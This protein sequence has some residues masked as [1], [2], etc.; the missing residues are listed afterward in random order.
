[1]AR[2]GQPNIR[3]LSIETFS[4]DPV[5][6]AAL[7]DAF[8]AM[9][10][11]PKT[12]LVGSFNYSAIHG[13]PTADPDGRTASPAQRAYWNQCHKREDQFFVWHRAY[14]RA[15]ERNLQILSGRPDLG[16]PY[17]DWYNSP[18]V[19]QIF[20]PE[21]LDTART[22]RNPL[23]DGRRDPS[24]KAGGPVWAPESSG[25]IDQGD[26]RTFQQLLNDN[27]HG[28]I[29]IG[30]AG[31][32]SDNMG[33]IATAARDPV[34]WLHHCNVD[35][36]LTAWVSHGGKVPDQSAGFDNVYKFPIENAPDYSPTA[37]VLDMGSATPSGAAYEKLD[38]P[39]NPAPKPVSRPAA[40]VRRGA[41]TRPLGSQVLALSTP[42][43]VDVPANGLNV[44]FAF[45]RRG[46]RN[47]LS[48]LNVPDLAAATS[49]VVV[50]DGVALAQ[51]PR[52][53]TGYDVYVN[54]PGG[55]VADARRFKLGS[56][57]I[58]ALTMEHGS[59][60]AM[61]ATFRFPALG[62]IRSN[63]GLGTDIRISLVPRFAPYGDATSQ[64]TGLRIQDV[65]V[66]ASNGAVM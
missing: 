31:G 9:G 27:E 18:T 21:F 45:P 51:P 6:V 47:L 48:V 32:P 38:A 49:V 35:R 61:P 1:M 39:F 33:R 22:R 66:E 7:R 58:F 34:F 17:W 59:G 19:P 40:T 60:M 30:V 24:V 62:T 56:I 53:L 10:A 43:P 8:S 37:G 36:L 20:L 42:T 44:E 23:F 12:A 25:A 2:A 41:A 5:L 26:F 57:P 64:A 4:N 3:R 54:L 14:L 28:A 13:M 50:L 15:L 55:T 52:G 46:D 63:G 29:H 11:R 65:R 16:L